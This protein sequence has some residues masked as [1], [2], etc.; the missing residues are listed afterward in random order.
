MHI[1]E[2]KAIFDIFKNAVSFDICY[3]F[4]VKFCH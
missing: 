3:A 1:V 4:L 2:N